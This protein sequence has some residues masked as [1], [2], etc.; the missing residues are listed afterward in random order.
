M[1]DVNEFCKI[2]NIPAS[3]ASSEFAPGQFEINLNHTNDIL[4]AA[5]DSA[6]L[7]RV[8]KETAIKHD[9]EAS[10]ISKPFIEQT[11]S[12]MHVHISLFDEKNQNIFSGDKEEGSEQLHYAIGGLQKTLYDNFLI[13]ASNV[14]SYRRFEPDQ[15]V[16][17]NN[18][19]GP[20]NR[21]V[22]FR[23]PRSDEK[24]K[25][26]EHRVAGAEA[27][28]YLVLSAILS[29]IHY[30]L[31]NKLSP[32]K[33]R[34]DNACTDPDPEMPKSIEKAIGLFED[35][36]FC[37]DYYSKEYVTMY[38]D[39]KR[40]EIESFRSEISDIEYKWYLNL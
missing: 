36:K 30:G 13:F 21:S 9:Y 4:K 1:E 10:F 29:G 33:L 5:D 34:I 8:I 25:R 20:N 26:I 7:R 3:T 19:W 40:K 22:A 31:I 23:I 32:T 17:V 38:S 35:S 15:F 27:N 12:G 6:L 37:I 14:N 18:S 16:P 28:S 24:S 39:L 2:Q 11:G